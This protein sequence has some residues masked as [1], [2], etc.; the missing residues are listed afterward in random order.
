MLNKCE[1]VHQICDFEIF[2]PKNEISPMC[3]VNLHHEDLPLLGD[4]LWGN[5]DNDRLRGSVACHF[6]W[7]LIEEKYEK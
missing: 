2:K 4:K 6:E 3:N 5:T 1:G 7:D